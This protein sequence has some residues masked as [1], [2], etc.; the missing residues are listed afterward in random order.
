MFKD[1]GIQ[2]LPI[3]ELNKNWKEY[4]LK[5]IL[6][7]LEYKAYKMSQNL[8]KLEKKGSKITT[9]IKSLLTQEEEKSKKKP[10]SSGVTKTLRRNP[11]P[12]KKK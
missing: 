5:T 2:F 4:V 3:Y 8:D 1:C 6:H 12:K 11:Y 10:K 7:H 9:I